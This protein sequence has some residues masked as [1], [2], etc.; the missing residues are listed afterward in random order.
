MADLDS[1]LRKIPHYKGKLS[2]SLRFLYPEDVESFIKDYFVGNTVTYPEF[3]STTFGST[4][5][6]DGQVQ[7]YIVGSKL[8]CD[9]SKYNNKEKEV[10]YARDNKFKVLRHSKKNGVHNIYL[11]EEK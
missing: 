3:L 6:P 1:A 4:Y 9:I 2:R 8:G 7:I 11:W 5:N 10:L